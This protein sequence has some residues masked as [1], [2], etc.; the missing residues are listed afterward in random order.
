MRFNQAISPTTLTISDLLLRFVAKYGY[1]SDTNKVILVP[2][3]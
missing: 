2:S 1:N 3:G